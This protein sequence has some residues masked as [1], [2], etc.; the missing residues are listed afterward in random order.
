MPDS[1]DYRVKP[2]SKVNLNKWSTD[3]DGEFD[4]EDVAEAVIDNK[5]EQLQDLQ[6]RLYAES[7][8]ALLVVFQAMDAGG[9]DG[10]IRHVFSGVNPQGCTVHSFKAPTTLEKAHDFLWRHHISCP[11]KGMISVHNRSHYESVL[12]ERVRGFV[13]KDIWKSRYNQ[14]NAF[15]ETLAAEGTTI[16]KFFLHISKD[17]QKKRFES[18]LKD[19]SK[20]WKFNRADLEERKFWDEYQKA[21]ED[22]LEECSTK[23]APWYVVP[24]DKKWFRNWVISDVLVRTLKDLKMEFPEAEAGLDKVRVK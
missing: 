10:A 20:H 19:E 22:L 3:D 8:H 9:K 11:P 14:I 18:R 6:H 17:E 16:I 24:S 15:E 21:Y 5:L 1:D 4:S 23:S 13:S 7:K 2:G 12:I